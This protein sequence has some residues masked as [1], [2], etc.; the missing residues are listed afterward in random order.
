MVVHE[1]K[2]PHR[3]ENWNV[4]A[5][6]YVSLRTESAIAKHAPNSKAVAQA[7]MTELKW[8]IKLTYKH[9]R[10][11]D[12]GDEAQQKSPKGGRG[13]GGANL[14]QGGNPSSKKSF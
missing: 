9:H 5:K 1:T 6:E 14:E 12:Q 13:R 7:I 8:A 10:R 4:A 2:C 11:F 3:R